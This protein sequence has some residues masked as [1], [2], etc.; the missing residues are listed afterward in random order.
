M[1]VCN[2]VV[3]D[4]WFV[5]VLCQMWF[6]WFFVYI[7]IVYGYLNNLL[8]YF[9]YLM[10]MLFNVFDGVVFDDWVVY[11]YDFV[12]L[13]MFMWLWL[14]LDY[15]YLFDD[16]FDDVFSGK[17]FLYSFIE[18]CYFVDF[19]WFNDM[20]LLYDVGYGDVFV[21]QVYNVLCSLL[22]WYQ[23]MFII[24]FDEYG[25]CFDYVLLFVVVLLS[26]LQFGQFFVFDWL[27]VCV[28]VVVVLLWIFKGM[29]FCLIV[30]QLYDY[31]VIIK[32]LCMCYNIWML[33]IVCD[34]SVFDLGQVLELSVLDDNCDLVVVCVMVVNLVGLQ[35][36]CN[37]LF[38]DFQWVMYELVVMFVLLGIGISIDD[39]V[40][41]LLID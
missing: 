23:M 40:C 41:N 31:I 15:F 17:L 38:N 18:L 4:V 34:V 5:L 21:V 12:Q 25:G 19:D 35:V 20:Y 3:C 11:Y 9:L 30:V 28:L 7:G 27:G 37:V 8:V 2:Y 16:F 29:I 24:I 6:N 14:Y 22:Q 39:Y 10:L 26:L 32:M 1:L 13:F 33:F 36:V